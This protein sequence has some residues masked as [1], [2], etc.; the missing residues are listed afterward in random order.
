MN[1]CFYKRCHTQPALRFRASYA[2]NA[3]SSIETPT[4]THPSAEALAAAGSRLRASRTPAG[5]GQERP[6]PG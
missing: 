1:I 3:Q 2:P 6:C 5:Q 4:P